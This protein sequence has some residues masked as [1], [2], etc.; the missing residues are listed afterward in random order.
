M[1][2]VGIMG[3]GL[4]LYN[5]TTPT[6]EELISRLSPELKQ[7]YYKNRELR[8]Q[9]QAALMEIVKKTSKSDDP[10][11]KTGE[12]AAPWGDAP[13]KKMLVA[14]EQF[15]RDQAEQFQRE[16][17]QQLKEAVQETEALETTKS[18]WKFW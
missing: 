10:I 13:G 14:K 16:K 18:S 9:E 4:L 6:D 11:W 1:A 7:E 17:I 5:F 12:L 8:R 15:E 2:S 3:T